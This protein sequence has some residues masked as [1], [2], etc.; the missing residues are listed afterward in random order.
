MKTF[1]SNA[2][3]NAAT[4]VASVYFMD[5]TLYYADDV[6]ILLEYIMVAVAVY[7]RG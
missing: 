6:T 2:S 5:R 1:P 3:Y 4:S 7:T